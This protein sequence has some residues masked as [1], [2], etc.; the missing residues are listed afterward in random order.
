MK[1]ILFVCMGNICR[2]PLAEGIARAAAVRAGRTHSFDSAGTLGYHAGEAPDPRARAVARQRG[3]PIDTQRARQVV[4]ADF[5]R[6]DLILAAD[7]QN[8]REL[9]RLR[10][11]TAGAELALLLEWA[12]IADGGEVPDPYYG[13]SADFEAV[14]DLLQS[15]C[16]AL[17]ARLDR[18]ASRLRSAGIIE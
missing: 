3:T 15:A 13:T 8:L 2:S 10:P 11:G 6:F 17:L 7:R 4:A 12:G 9:Q 18:D 1:N 14:Y 5:Q 16:Q